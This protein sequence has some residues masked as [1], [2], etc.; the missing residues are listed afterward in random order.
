MFVG[1]VLFTFGFFCFYFVLFVVVF[2]V[3]RRKCLY[4]VYPAYRGVNFT[5]ISNPGGRGGGGVFR[6][7][8]EGG[9]E[10]VGVGRVCCLEATN[11]VLSFVAFDAVH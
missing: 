8:G 1:L 7:E 9:G 11:L 3:K 2:A 5:S 6:G 10:G 4:E